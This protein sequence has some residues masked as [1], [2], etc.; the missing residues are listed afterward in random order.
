MRQGRP[1]VSDC[2]SGAGSTSRR[3]ARPSGQQEQ[4]LPGSA[5]QAQAAVGEASS[6]LPTAQPAAPGQPQLRQSTR[7]VGTLLAQH[8]SQHLGAAAQINSTGDRDDQ[9]ALDITRTGAARRRQSR[10]APAAAGGSEPDQD[11]EDVCCERTQSGR[12]Q[13]KRS[14]GAASPASVQRA[15]AEQCSAQPAENATGT[16]AAAL[17]A[18]ERPAHA[19]ACT[20]E[21]GAAAGQQASP[22][23]ATIQDG[24][25][26]GPRQRQ[27]GTGQQHQQAAAANAM[28]TSVQT[29]VPEGVSEVGAVGGPARLLGEPAATPGQ[30]PPNEYVMAASAQQRGLDSPLPVCQS[31]MSR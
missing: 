24:A 12:G 23:Q 5:R 1:D 19:Q 20:D 16:A 3:A 7:A 11:A 4:L 22:Q 10:A 27:L 28:G 6:G 13:D 31:P 29:D 15:P 17:S 2:H 9:N 30:P 14:T 8:Q 18:A 21:A 25:S 26:Q